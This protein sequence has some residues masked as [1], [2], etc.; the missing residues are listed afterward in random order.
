MT[1]FII[2]YEKKKY[3]DIVREKKRVFPNSISYHIFIISY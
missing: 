1:Y 2:S 3:V